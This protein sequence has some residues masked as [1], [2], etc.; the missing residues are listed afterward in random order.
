[1]VR[2]GKDQKRN[3]AVASRCPELHLADEGDLPSGRRSVCL[4]GTNLCRVVLSI[5]QQEKFLRQAL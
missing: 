1:M 3:E 2:E 4:Q 5:Y